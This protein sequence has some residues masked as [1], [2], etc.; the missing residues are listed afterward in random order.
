MPRKSTKHLHKY[1][2]PAGIVALILV[3][4]LSVWALGGSDN[5]AQDP[6]KQKSPSAS[7]DNSSEGPNSGSPDLS[8]ATPQEKKATDDYK[9]SLSPSPPSPT[10]SSG[11]KQVYPVITG[12]SSSE[13]DAYVSGVIESGGTCSV[14]ATKGSEAVSGSS[15]GFANVSYTSCQ[16]IHLSL[17]SG[18]W[19]INLQYSSATAQGQVTQSFEVN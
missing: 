18:N 6:D 11:K 4:S 5:H 10:G 16:P 1:L 8:P 3:A 13:V 2:L 19:S 9:Q 12:A 15:S 17:S 14:S 7:S